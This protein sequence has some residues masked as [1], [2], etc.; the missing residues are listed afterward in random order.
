MGVA[1]ACRLGREGQV[2]VEKQLEASRHRDSVDERQV[3]LRVLGHA[4]EQ[5]VQVA[6]ELGESGPVAL[7]RLILLEVAAGTEGAAGTGDRDQAH[8]G[9]G[10]ELVEGVAQRQDRA[11]AERV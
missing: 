11:P 9:V 5:G 1:D 4:G 7:E 8:V 3:R 2:A 10:R 6:E